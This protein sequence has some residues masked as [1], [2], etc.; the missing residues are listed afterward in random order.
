MVAVPDRL[1][2]AVGKAQH[3]D[4]LHRFL[5]EIVIDPVDLVLVHQLQEFGIEVLGRFEVGAEWFFHHQPSPRR[6][7]FLQHAGAAE[8]LRDRQEGARRGRQIEQP[9]AAGLALGFDLL[10]LAAHGVERGGILVVGLDAGDAGEQLFGHRVVDLAGRELPQARHQAFGQ[11]RGRHA[12]AGDADEAEVFGQEVAGGEI[13][14]RGN[15]QAVR[16]IA[17]DAEQDEAAIVGLL[18]NLRHDT[19]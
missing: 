3:Q 19:P 2:H 10:K 15:H 9:V 16:E 5:A 8:L 12:L 14:E 17:G 7:V 6:P 13:I 18:L 1:E 11:L 4:V